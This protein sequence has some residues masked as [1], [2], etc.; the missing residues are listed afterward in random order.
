MKCNKPSC[1]FVGW[2]GLCFY[3]V[4]FL[5]C[6]F[7]SC[8]VSH[9]QVRLRG[10]YANIKQG[11]FLLFSPDGKIPRID[12]LHVVNGEFEYV[13]D[14][15]GE[16]TLCILYPNNSQLMLWARGGDDLRIEADVQDLWNT[17]VKGNPENELYTGFRRQNAP[18]DTVALRRSAAG[19]IRQHAGSPVASY[20][21]RQYFVAPYDVPMDSTECLYRVIQEALPQDAG[22]T[23]LGGVIQQCY[24]LQEG[25]PM[26]AFDLVTTDSVHHRLSD[27][28][29]KHLVLYFWAGWHSSSN[30]LHQQLD[31]LRR[32]LREPS[33]EGKRKQDVALLGFSLDTDTLTFR[34]S[35]PTKEQD[36]PTF[37]DQQGFNHPLL[38][39]LGVRSLPLFIVVGTDGKVWKVASEFREVERY[40]SEST[41]VKKGKRKET[42]ELS[43][44]VSRNK[45]PS[46]K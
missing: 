42:G 29:G 32:E 20:L 1:P 39:Q 33:E 11:D 4:C 35:Q 34:V 10:K 7:L 5:C 36:I 3:V 30:Y 2:A 46:L 14:F 8:G 17:V 44:A 6:T 22:V 38:T 41:Q 40:F 37:C 28:K 31:N 15:E 12:T 13:C 18:T 43:R 23:R 21:L 26:P 9:D 25:M 19:F 24:A 16:G 45:T 27:Y